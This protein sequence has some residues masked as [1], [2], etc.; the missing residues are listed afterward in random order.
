MPTAKNITQTDRLAILH[1][2]LER[3]EGDALEH[4]ALAQASRQFGFSRPTLTI[5]WK[6]WKARRAASETG[7]W[8]VTSDKK[9]NGSAIKYDRVELQQ[10]VLGMRCRSRRTVRSLAAG[11][12]ISKSH[13]QR[14]IKLEGILI[15][16]TSTLK[17][18]LTEYNKFE[19]V[20]F[21][22]SERR[23]NDN[24]MYK[25]MYDRVHVDEKWFYITKLKDRY[26]LV[27]G[28]PPPERTTSH[29]NHI[30][31]VMF[32]C[33]VARPRWD[34]GRNQWFDGKIGMWPV[35]HQVP[36]ART[37]VNRVRGTL[38]WKNL[39]MDKPRYTEFLLDKV[40]P[41]IREKFPVT[42]QPI[43]I[44]QDNATPHASLEAWGV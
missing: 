42:N 8:D 15:P 1:F 21:C 10:T 33:A 40:L 6:K 29:K 24:G 5:L 19:R 14:M 11:L 9:S 39:I 23:E 43:H 18:K 17:P 13:L 25:E 38:E 2:L 7:E 36:A 41:A 3:L 26:Y 4:G 12:E 34:P 31:K 28:E 22:L 27:P 44:Q 35:A 32:L 30:P 16:H 20:E 37:S